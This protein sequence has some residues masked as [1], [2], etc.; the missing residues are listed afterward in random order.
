MG[1][2]GNQVKSMPAENFISDGAI[3]KY[4]IAIFGSAD[5]HTAIAVDAATPCLGVTGDLG[6]DGSG[7]R[8]DVFTKGSQRVYYGGTVAAGDMLKP[9]A[10]GG[11]IATTTPGD[12]VVGR[13]RISGVS[14][15]IGTVEINPD[16]Y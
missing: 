15:D 12:H 14:G 8:I 7:K 11:A 13:A 6:V 5:G 9:D 2:S 1:A 10:N 3:G 16:I 4:R